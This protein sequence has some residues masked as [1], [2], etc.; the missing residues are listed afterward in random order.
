MKLPHF[1]RA[2]IKKRDEKYEAT[3]GWKYKETLNRV[4]LYF[5]CLYVK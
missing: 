4:S 5:F 2:I 3:R 1:G